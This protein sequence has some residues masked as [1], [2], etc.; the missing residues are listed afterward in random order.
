MRVILE[1]ISYQRTLAYWI[2]QVQEKH[3]IYFNIDE[4]KNHRASKEDRI[5]GL[6]P[7]FAA[8]KI[9]IKPEMRELESELLS[10]PYGRHDDL[11]DVLAM[12]LSFIV[13]NI[14][15]KKAITYKRKYYKNSASEILDEIKATQKKEGKLHW[16]HD[17]G[18]LGERIKNKR[19]SKYIR[20]K[21][22]FIFN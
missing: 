17:M 7:Y 13:E 1:G 14:K 2:K 15:I 8:T 4:I 19:R 6:Q 21:Q 5:K 9:F 18:L 20:P 10:F 12:F 11:V 22:R 3:S 16:T